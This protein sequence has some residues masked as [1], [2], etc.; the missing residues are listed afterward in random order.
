MTHSAAAEDEG[1]ATFRFLEEYPGYLFTAI[2]VLFHVTQSNAIGL[3]I[4]MSVY[5][6]MIR[7]MAM[8]AQQA[9]SEPR[10][11]ADP[12]AD[13]GQR[14]RVEESLAEEDQVVIAEEPGEFV[15]EG[16]AHQNT[17]LLTRKKQRPT[18]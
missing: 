2:L 4:S 1:L 13:E 15:K 3:I 17:W 11:E 9:K 10:R 18:A 5:M 14:R 12:A 6:A 7:P 16:P 8:V